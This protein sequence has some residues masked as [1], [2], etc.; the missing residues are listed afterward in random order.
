M[1]RTADAT[2]R[3]FIESDVPRIKKLAVTTS[4]LI[5]VTREG[6]MVVDGQGSVAKTK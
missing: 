2:V 4:S 5:I 6:V 1:L 3:G